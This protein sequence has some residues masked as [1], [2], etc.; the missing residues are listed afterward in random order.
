VSGSD[1]S[2]STLTKDDIRRYRENIRDEVDGAALYRALAD[3]EE[4]ERLS[5]IYRRL[6]ET[7]DRHRAVWE[8]H[9]RTA[10]ADVPA[11]KPSRRVRMLGWLARRFGADSIAPIAMRMEANAYTMYDNQPEAVARGLP[12]DERSHARIFREIARTGFGR[13]VPPIARIEGRHRAVSGNA[14]RAAIL[15]ANDG[16]VSNLSL[17]M[18][19]AGANPGSNVV[20]VTGLAGLVAGALSMALGEWISVQNSHEYFRH[21]LQVERDELDV[22][23]EEEME[24]LVLIYQAKG[25]TE[26]EARALADR[27]FENREEALHT[28]AREELG[29]GEELGGN[30]WIA[31]LVSFL[32]FGTGAAMPVIPWFVF[33]GFL[34][35][36]GSL[37]LA[38]LAL[39]F[40]GALITF[41]T[42][43][44]I[45]FS[46]GRM[47]LFGMACAAITFGIGLLI[48]MAA[49]I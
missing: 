31:A 10:G 21:E 33:D 42:A 25:F 9:L 43:R 27:V 12:R 46:A 30:P 28:L 14:I 20:L 37:V 7:E 11:F 40:T 38:G 49:D 22:M 36:V 13:E 47:L 2:P 6:A 1:S 35:V 8:E 19:M 32:T 18:G 48:G 34:A 41:Y 4:D 45:W 5:G 23:P 39:L 17:V 44:N 3:A 16:L 29:M 24:E 15:G 26:H